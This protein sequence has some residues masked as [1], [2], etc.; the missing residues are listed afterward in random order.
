MCSGTQDTGRPLALTWEAS[1]WEAALQLMSSMEQS[2]LEANLIIYNSVTCRSRE[3]R[4]W[5]VWA[6]RSVRL[7]DEILWATAEWNGCRGRRIRTGGCQESAIASNWVLQCWSAGCGPTEA[8][9][10]GSKAEEWQEAPG[11]KK[12]VR[13]AHKHELFIILWLDGIILYLPDYMPLRRFATPTILGGFNR[14]VFGSSGLK[15]PPRLEPVRTTALGPD[16]A[17]IQ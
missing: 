2:M 9:S 3:S 11:L 15:R 13:E 10:A 7:V 5:F 4:V 17:Q 1:Y 6:G 14:P 16:L 12:D 8:M